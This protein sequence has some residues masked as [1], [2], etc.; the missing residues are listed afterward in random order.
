VSSCLSWARPI[1]STPPH[2][3]S[4]RSILILSTNPHLGLPSGLLP[5]GL[6]TNKLY[7]FLFARIRA[8]CAAYLNLLDWDL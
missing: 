6:P 7:A 2:P 8:T 4:P 3:T 1:Q 5:S